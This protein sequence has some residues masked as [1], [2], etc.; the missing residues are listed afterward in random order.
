M[1]PDFTLVDQNGRT[2]T[3]SVQRGH[4]LAIFFGYTHCPDECPLTLAHLA[5]AMHSPS[6]PHDLRVVFITVDPQR[7]TPATLKRYIG[8]FDRNFVGLTGSLAKLDPVYAAYGTPRQAARAVRGRD[9]Y[10]VAHGT[11]IYFVSRDGSLK[12]FAQWDD[13][14]ALIARDF[15]DFQ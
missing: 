2:F 5:K 15:H 3:L 4:P 1:A 7:D 11:T 8:F 12:G 13:G 10:S 9:D 6:A 14:I